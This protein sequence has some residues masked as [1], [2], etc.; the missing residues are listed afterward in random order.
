MNQRGNIPPRAPGQEP[1]FG[2]GNVGGEI[3]SITIL[4]YLKKSFKRIFTKR[5]P[6]QVSG[7]LK[8]KYKGQLQMQISHESIYKYIYAKAKGEL[9][10]HLL[11]YLRQKGRKNINRKLSHEKEDRTLMLFLY[12]K[13]QKKR[14]TDKYLDIGKEIL[15]WEKITKPL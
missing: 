6:E 9:K 7:Y 4:I 1:W 12:T 8:G 3:K 15:S 11:K 13:D 14:K 5:S 10:K 2:A